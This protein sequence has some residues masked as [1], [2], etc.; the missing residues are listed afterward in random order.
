MTVLTYLEEILRDN[1]KT[2]KMPTGTTRCGFVVPIGQYKY[3]DF[4]DATFHPL[5]DYHTIPQTP[6]Y[7]YI[8][9]L[10]RSNDS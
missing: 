6:Q 2:H 1:A 3:T 8:M 7:D 9:S 4:A 5:E 10:L